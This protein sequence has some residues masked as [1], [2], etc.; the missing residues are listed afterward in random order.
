MRIL[1]L[2]LCLLASRLEA[3]LLYVGKNKPFTNITAAVA[4][5]KFGDTIMVDKG[6]YYEK[7]L[8]ISKSITL[9]GIDYP[10]LDGENKY[11]NISV[12]ADFVKIEGFK[13]RRSGVSSIVDFAG[14]KIYNRKW[15]SV[16]NNIL[17]DCFFGI[18]V[19][20]GLHCLIAKNK[21]TASSKIE[22]QS[23]NGIHAWKSNKLHI[24]L[25]EITGHRDG[26]YFEFVTN[27]EIRGNLSYN[28]LRYGLHFM[29]SNN[30][31]YYNNTFKH[32]GAGVA[33]MFS[34][35]IMMKGNYF[36]KNQGDA[37][38]GI[39]LKEINDG[40]IEY[41]H[42]EN[43]TT[44]ILAEGSNRIEMKYNLFKEN[45]WALKVQANC[46]DINLNH[47][48]FM[49]NSFDIG[50]NG[51]LVLNDF[52]NNYWDKY[53]GYDLNKDQIGDVPYRPVSMFSMVVER[54][55]AAMMLFR[56]LI[57]TVMDKSEKIAPSLTPENL[58]DNNPLMKP[59][60]L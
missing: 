10:I 21:L 33:V 49:G 29:F 58:I 17:E 37:A 26:I 31:A 23:G 46:M 16:I 30:D 38:Y 19:Q 8:I 42:F 59:V 39:L 60:R 50:T 11:E 43:N 57:A 40:L 13:I 55:P 18:Y 1:T 44:A 48:N 15:V 53:E 20:N 45:G 54:N 7:N 9:I 25:N 6:L 12:K 36:I 32:N 47:N 56:S 35:G 52:N 27:S 28:N 2:I 4:T 3:A 34:K 14:I 5:A 24:L 22:S 51:S 41:N